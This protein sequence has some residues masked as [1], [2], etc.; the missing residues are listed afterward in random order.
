MYAASSIYGMVH[1][2][3]YYGGEESLAASLAKLTPTY[4]D[5]ALAAIWSQFVH[6]TIM[7]FLVLALFGALWRVWYSSE[8]TRHRNPLWDSSYTVVGPYDGGN[9]WD[10]NARNTGPT[11][12][13]DFASTRGQ[14]LG[15]DGDADVAAARAEFIRQTRQN[16]QNQNQG[17]AGSG[18]NGGSDA[19]PQGQGFRLGDEL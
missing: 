19:N 17:Q 2:I 11:Q 5:V 16:M 7:L 4:R 18:G 9:G 1:V 6:S 13:H 3:Y 10:G 8:V 15:S 14:A 12:R